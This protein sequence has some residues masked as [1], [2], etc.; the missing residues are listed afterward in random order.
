MEIDESRPIQL[1]DNVKLLT[2]YSIKI[3]NGEL[4][5]KG[6]CYKIE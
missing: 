2:N 4:I 3:E 5:A 1:E 6:D